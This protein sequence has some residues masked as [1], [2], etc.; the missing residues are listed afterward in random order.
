[1]KTKRRNVLPAT[2][3]ASLAGPMAEKF[4]HAVQTPAAAKTFSFKRLVAERRAGISP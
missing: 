3:C 1:M 4:F 2:A